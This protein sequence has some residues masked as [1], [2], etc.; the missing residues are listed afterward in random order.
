MAR[1]F[2]KKV[3]E[4][5]FAC[6]SE[7]GIVAY[8]MLRVLPTDPTGFLRQIQNGASDF[9]FASVD[10]ASISGLTIFS[11]LG[12]GSVGFGNPDGAVYFEVNKQPFMVFYEAKLNETYL[13]SCS[14]QSYNSTIQGQLELKW[15]LLNLYKSGEIKT[16]GDHRCIVESAEYASHYAEFD[17]FYTPSAE[18]EDPSLVRQ[19][20][21][22][23]KGGVEEVFTTYISKC[24]LDQVFFLASTNDTSNPLI[25]PATPPH[26]LPR[27]FGKSW[28]AAQRQFCWISN[29]VIENCPAL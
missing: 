10:S 26:K 28:E 5:T 6:Y 7:R 16:D 20:R 23:L 21:L 27:C 17:K 14:G 18:E 8:F 4:I 25:N 2:N 15:R 22:L 13:Q 3:G 19:R 29:K 1:L 9:P 11:E 24:H 12:F